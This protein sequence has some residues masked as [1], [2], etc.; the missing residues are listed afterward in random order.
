MFLAETENPPGIND[1]FTDLNA[2]VSLLR[3]IIEYYTLP[4]EAVFS[5]EK[6]TEL[7]S[8]LKEKR[9]KL[10]EELENYQQIENVFEREKTLYI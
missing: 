3:F 10:E 1:G 9:K 7:A 4:I 5:N 2:S 6:I 8:D